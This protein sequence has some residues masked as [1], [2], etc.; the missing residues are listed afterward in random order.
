M[1]QLKIVKIESFCTSLHIYFDR[2]IYDYIGINHIIRRFEH[3]F[4]NIE[5]INYKE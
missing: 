2:K 4:K 5:S 3:I 1:S